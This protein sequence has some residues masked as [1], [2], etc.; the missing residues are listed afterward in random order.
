MRTDHFSN[1]ILA[2][3]GWLSPTFR[4]DHPTPEPP[5]QVG[6]ATRI[7]RNGR[8]CGC[9]VNRKKCARPLSRTIPSLPN[10]SH[11]P[12]K[13][14][15][16]HAMSQ[17]I[18]DTRHYRPR[19]YGLTNE[20]GRKIISIDYLAVLTIDVPFPLFVACFRFVSSLR[21]SAR[22]L[23]PFLVAFPP[24]PPLAEALSFATCVFECS[25]SDVWPWPV[26]PFP[27]MFPLH[28]TLMYWQPGHHFSFSFVGFCVCFCHFG[29][30][31]LGRLRVLYSVIGPVPFVLSCGECVFSDHQPLRLVHPLLPPDL[32]VC[33]V[34]SPG[35]SV[36]TVNGMKFVLIVS[37]CPR[38][39][40]YGWR[41]WT[42]LRVA[43]VFCLRPRSPA[44][45]FLRTGGTLRDVVFSAP[46]TEN[47]R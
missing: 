28:G 35:S 36:R 40:G 15:N 39:G 1:L 25:W 5:S 9:D 42:R 37:R 27:F 10:L 7:E 16:P 26:F 34:L 14:T 8:K 46:N 22:V 12:T 20:I 3:P 21:A 32:P 38:I 33:F 13:P 24:E 2:F 18:A 6:D 44:L 47:T 30:T 45:R 4:V 29:C 19:P 41:R 11:T 31:S 17:S 23:F 43:R